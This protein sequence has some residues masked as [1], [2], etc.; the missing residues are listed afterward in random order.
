MAK[1][2]IKDK[3]GE[4]KSETIIAESARLTFAGGL[5][6][7]VSG[8]QNTVALTPSVVGNKRYAADPATYTWNDSLY[9]PSGNYG[10]LSSLGGASADDRGDSWLFTGDCNVVELGENSVLLD[11]MCE[12]CRDCKDIFRL[13]KI[14]EWLYG[15]TNQ[16][17][18]VNLYGQATTDARADFVQ[19]YME[20]TAAASPCFDALENKYKALG[21]L[22]SRQLMGQYIV[23]VHMYNYLAQRIGCRVD[24]R[25]IGD[26]G[27]FE[28]RTSRVVPDCGGQST[29]AVSVHLHTDS[30]EAA[31]VS[32]YVPPAGLAV[33]GASSCAIDNTSATKTIESATDKTFAYGPIT[34]VCAGTYELHMQFFPLIN[35]VVRDDNGQIVDMGS[36]ESFSANPESGSTDVNILGTTVSAP[37]VHYGASAL[38]NQT[39]VILD[40][41]L[42]QYEAGSTYPSQTDSGKITWSVD[43]TW[44]LTRANGESDVV[45][46]TYMMEVQ[47]PRRPADREMITGYVVKL[48]G[49]A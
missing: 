6:I 1:L 44:T 3:N 31:D 15:M 42:E 32:V 22:S 11:N 41:T 29:V 16:L 39:S 49:G 9:P 46:D 18:D 36:P 43:I 28:L 14:I 45:E 5:G 13:K 17:K 40:P 7:T 10:Y 20:L 19:S 37:A 8:S 35:T 21:R 12:A 25:K 48:P 33:T 47:A 34:V 27:A 2:I 30:D 38:H 24:M 23:A 4:T 26:S